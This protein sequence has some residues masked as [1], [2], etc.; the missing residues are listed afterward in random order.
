MADPDPD[1]E[2]EDKDR[3]AVESAEDVEES[4][5]RSKAVE[6]PD[7]E[8]EEVPKD[9]DD[10]GDGGK[11]KGAGRR[12]LRSAAG[13]AARFAY[14]HRNELMAALELLKEQDAVSDT[15]GKAILEAYEE[16]D[17]KTRSVI[18]ELV[19]RLERAQFGKVVI[20]IREPEGS[21]GDES[22]PEGTLPE[23]APRGE[24]EARR[25]APEAKKAAGRPK[26]ATPSV[27]PDASAQIPVE[28]TGRRIEETGRRVVRGVGSEMRDQGEV[29]VEDLVKRGREAL[30]QDETKELERVFFKWTT[31]T[32][33]KLEQILVRGLIGAG[34]VLIVVAILWSAHQVEA[35]RDIVRFASVF[36][37]VFTGI[38][39][40]T[41]SNRVSE[42]AHESRKDVEDL[43]ATRPSE[44]LHRMLGDDFPGVRRPKPFG[45]GSS[46]E[47]SSA[48]PP[49]A[50]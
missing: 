34:V 42:W 1:E 18:E 17:E 26:A 43:V 27:G 33:T 29:M 16:A 30:V 19:E 50:K 25:T 6:A 9:H 3:R 46:S 13:T 37:L 12:L 4:R 41:W 23:D 48:D 5:D 45:G 49:S 8:A 38:L 10:E 44:R 40:I 36:L 20:G 14:E 11:K 22:T 47:P 7:S 15:D 32:I 2:A 31:E 35:L 24:K 39:L 21:P 28:E